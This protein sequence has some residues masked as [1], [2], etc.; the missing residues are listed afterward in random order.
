M[1]WGVIWCVRPGHRIYDPECRSRYSRPRASATPRDRNLLQ[2]MHLPNG[3]IDP[4]TSPEPA[5]TST[6]STATMF[7][8]VDPRAI[9][10]GKD[11]RISA[12]GYRPSFATQR[13]IPGRLEVGHRLAYVRFHEGKNQTVCRA[14][15]GGRAIGSFEPESGTLPFRGDA[16]GYRRAGG[17]V[18]RARR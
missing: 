4:T 1:V 11:E 3:A 8:W 10:A 6:E 13:L 9:A 12:H 7:R 16:S 14:P 18:Q 17:A 2:S 5:P 15:A